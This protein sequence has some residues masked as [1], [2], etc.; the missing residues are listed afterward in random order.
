MYFSMSYLLL[1]VA[2]LVIGLA[3][4]AGINA[5]YRKWSR[6]PISTGQT[7]F[8]AARRMLDAN[9]LG[10][11]GIQM[12]NTSDL[13][14]HYDPRTNTLGLSRGVYNGTSVAATAVAC[15][16]AGHAVQ[17]ARG[18]LPARAR[19]AIFPAVSLASNAW[20]FV[21]FLGLIMGIAS[22]EWLGVILFALVLVFQL[23]TLPVE[24]DASHRGLANIRALYPWM[25]E[26][27][28]GGARK[29][30]T[31]AALTYVAS[32]LSS[33]LQLIYFAGLARE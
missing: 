10:H 32:A 33:A 5:A 1:M 14:D 4:Q 27:Q 8:Q 29:V 20:I 23:V 28:L 24:F 9:G 26:M 31:A 18:Y 17:H 16:E 30:L 22:L 7:G 6:V 11:V 19:L 3:A 12:L 15:H 25:D 21:F 13:S 2:V